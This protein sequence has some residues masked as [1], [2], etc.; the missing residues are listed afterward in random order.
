[1]SAIDG[2]FSCAKSSVFAHVE[3][4]SSSPRKYGAFESPIQGGFCP[5]E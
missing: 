4:E 1:M 5:L 2:A 3:T